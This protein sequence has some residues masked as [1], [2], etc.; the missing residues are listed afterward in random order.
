MLTKQIKEVPV[1]SKALALNNLMAHFDLNGNLVVQDEL[2]HV[3]ETEACIA[4][5]KQQGHLKTVLATVWVPSASVLLTEVFVPGKRKSDWMAALPYALEESLS[6]PVEQF[7]FVAFHKS[8]D[9]RV[10]VAIVPHQKMTHWVDTLESLG[11]GHAQLLPECFRVPF[12]GNV[13]EEEA[14]WFVIQE[15]AQYHVRTGEYSGFSA[16]KNGLELF[17]KVAEQEGGEISIVT[18]NASELLDSQASSV[19]HLTLRTEEYQAHSKG[20]MYWRNWRWPAFWV[21]LLLVASLLFTWQKTQR[22]A[23]QTQ[24]YKAETERLFKTLFPDVKR[25]VNIKMQ[26]QTRLNAVSGN[27]NQSDSLVML[28]KE[29]EPLFLADPNVNINAIQWRT[30]SQGGQLQVSVEA[31]QT[32]QLQMIVTMSQKKVPSIK[33]EL[34][35]KNVTPSLVEGVFHVRF[36]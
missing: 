9:D 17:K 33:V 3:L 7:H 27:Q 19:A 36:Q 31:A 23:E 16:D 21:L 30:D 8:K 11:L 24:Q 13:S 34:E 18:L 28:L 4:Q 12:K 10:S 22:L 6:E 1:E 35:L 15:Q 20:L 25:I 14:T 2:G 29:I 26:T 5:L 32:S